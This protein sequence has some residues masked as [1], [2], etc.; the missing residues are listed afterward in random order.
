MFATDRDLLA[1]EPNLFR[2]LVWAGQR[3]PRGTSSISGTTLTCSSPETLFDAA[4]VTTGHVIVA[5]GIG[6]E[7]ISRLST[8][9]LS[10]SRP[11][12]ASTSPVLPPT[13]ATNVEAWVVTFAPQMEVVHRQ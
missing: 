4:G 5:N 13:A 11:R 2:D 6:H 9:Q 7:V 12:A 10:I 8:T 1:L 3:L